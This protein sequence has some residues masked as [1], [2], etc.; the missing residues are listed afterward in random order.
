M[1]KIAVLILLLSLASMHF[2]CQAKQNNAQVVAS[3]L[4]VYEFTSYICRNTNIG[5]TRLITENVSCLHDYTLKVAQMRAIETAEIIMIS[6]AGLEDFL[7]DALVSADNIIDTSNGVSLIVSS[8]ET[9]H[10]EH[11]HAHHAQHDPHIWL[12]PENAKIMA[13]NI[14][15]ALSEKYP[16]FEKQFK[17]NLSALE[18]DL[19]ALSNYAHKQLSDIT[20]RNI[21]TFHDG[22]S[23]MAKSFGLGIVYTVEEESGS[24]TSAAELIALTRIISDQQVKAIFTETNG[25]SSAATIIANE[26]GIPVYTLDMAMSDRDYFEA[27]YHNIDTLKEALQ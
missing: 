6:G 9:C 10:D 19:D 2:G 23:Y 5:V 1:K 16:E 14:A 20:D 21:I 7:S 25:S 18:E 27:M 15:N 17:S 4:P 24:E 8:K 22:F 12:S 11:D 13:N 26:I 3:T